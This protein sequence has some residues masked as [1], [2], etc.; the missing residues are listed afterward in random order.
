WELLTVLNDLTT[1][2][3]INTINRNLANLFLEEGGDMVK[4]LERFMEIVAEADAAGLSWGRVDR[5]KCSKFF[6]TLPHELIGITREWRRLD[7]DEQTFLRL[8]R[9]YN[10]EDAGRKSSAQR[11]MDTMAMAATRTTVKIRGVAKKTHGGKSGPS[12]GKGKSYP[13]PSSSKA[14]SG[15]RAPQT[16]S[17]SKRLLCYGCGGRDHVRPDCPVASQHGPGEVICWNC[18]QPGH[19]QPQCTKPRQSS[20]GKG[21]AKAYAAYPDAD[22]ML[23]PIFEPESDVLAASPSS[24]LVPFMVDSGASQHIV[25]RVDLL[26][27]ARKPSKPLSFKTVGSKKTSELIGDVTGLLA[28]GRRITFQDVVLLPGAGVN[29]LSEELLRERGWIK[30]V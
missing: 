9:L 6:D 21:K 12:H 14:I 23:A 19:A 22:D 24:T 8:V 7:K 25:D 17:S 26:V 15:G 30:V 28:S 16:S 2:D 3:H 20:S 13:S 5:E 1:P 29:L 10:E 18:H 4:H 27:N 11:S